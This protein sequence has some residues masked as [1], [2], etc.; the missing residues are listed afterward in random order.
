MS[1]LPGGVSGGEVLI[2]MLMLVVVGGEVLQ[3]KMK[4][5]ARDVQ[6]SGGMQGRARWELPSRDLVVARIEARARQLGPS[7]R[8]GICVCGWTTASERREVGCEDT[9]MTA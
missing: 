3:S 8:C 2:M 9:T 4:F 1:D 6:S 5:M 7:V